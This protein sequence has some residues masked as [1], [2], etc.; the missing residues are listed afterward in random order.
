MGG[1]Q[2]RRRRE[3]EVDGGHEQG[4]ADEISNM[5]RN[6]EARFRFA[7]RWRP[8]PGALAFTS[9]AQVGCRNSRPLRHQPRKP[10]FDTP[11]EAADALSRRRE[12]MTCR[13]A[14]DLRPRG[15]RPVSSGDPVQDKNTLPAFAAMAAGE[16]GRRS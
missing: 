3:A 16:E 7:L 6:S 9:Q 13:A 5:T 15:Q 14:G 2:G 4:K 11:Q 12:R 1:S 10:G 8:W